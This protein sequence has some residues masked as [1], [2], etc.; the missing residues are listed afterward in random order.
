M[1]LAQAADMMLSLRIGPKEAAALAIIDEMAGTAQMRDIAARLEKR[2]K[3]PR[4]IVG[5]L[6][7]KRLAMKIENPTGFPFYKL[8][9]LTELNIHD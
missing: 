3:C 7:Q 4:A 5:I 1:N 6:M 2:S 8:T 9:K